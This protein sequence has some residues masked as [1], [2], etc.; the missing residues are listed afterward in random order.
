MYVIT[1]KSHFSQICQ[2]GE[3]GRLTS[4]VRAKLA[5]FWS[6]LPLKVREYY[7]VLPFRNVT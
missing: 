6:L 4:D 7:Y 2:L 3:F 5:G 1:W